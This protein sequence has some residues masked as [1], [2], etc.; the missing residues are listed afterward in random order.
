MKDSTEAGSLLIVSGTGKSSRMIAGL[1][2]PSL[3]SSVLMEKTGSATRQLAQTR[4][5]RL[6]IINS[7]LSDEYG[8]ELAAD[9]AR[10]TTAGVIL[11]VRA[12]VYGE[13]SDQVNRD[14]VITVSKP[15]SAGLF[16]QAVRMGLAQSARL[17]AGA[18]EI[19][20][21]KEKLAES[22]LVG[23]AK[24]IL[25][26]ARGISEAEA[27]RKIEKQAMDARVSLRVAAEETIRVWGENL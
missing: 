22:R 27:H 9:L 13:V 2:E 3:V 11:L 14:G 19:Q 1:L 26:A 5:L 24:C 18:N 8:H 6:I 10:Q 23:R 12:D 17:T 21:L 4:P 16:S 25:V 15:L 20:R 7:P